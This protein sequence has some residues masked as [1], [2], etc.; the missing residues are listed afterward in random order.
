MLT[1]QQA[2]L[3]NF[4]A[5]RLR[6]TGGV[7]PSVSEMAKGVGINSKSGVHRL[8]SGLEERGFIHR[9]RGRARAIEIVRM[10]GEIDLVTDFRR[11]AKALEAKHG[12]KATVDAL[13]DL[14]RDMLADQERELMASRGMPRLM[15]GRA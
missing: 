12:T 11:A 1:A 8:L 9:L 10:P 15:A 4:I 3:V 14:I 6:A 7:A 5:D 13:T 2:A